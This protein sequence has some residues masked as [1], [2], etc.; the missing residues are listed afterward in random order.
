MNAVYVRNIF[1]EIYKMAHFEVLS[2]SMKTHELLAKYLRKI[3]TCS[4][5]VPNGY[6]FNISGTSIRYPCNSYNTINYD[7][8]CTI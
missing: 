5:D 4:N 6:Y 2:N 8:K 1:Y 3:F 7:K